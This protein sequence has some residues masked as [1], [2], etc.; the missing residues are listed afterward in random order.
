MKFRT[1]P[2][3]PIAFLRNLELEKQRA[4]AGWKIRQQLPMDGFAP[5]SKMKAVN[6]RS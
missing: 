6:P 3:I 4:R 1:A 5:V 2:T